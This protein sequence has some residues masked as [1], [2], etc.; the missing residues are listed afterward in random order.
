MSRSI[1]DQE[2]SERMRVASGE[3]NDD[4]PLVTFLYLLARNELPIGTIEI[5]LGRVADRHTVGD[6]ALTN[7]W[8]ARWA[9]DAAER[10]G[11]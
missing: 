5:I 3:V 8:L 4:R 1:A 9:Q 7:G 6:V 2:R 11:A 10:L